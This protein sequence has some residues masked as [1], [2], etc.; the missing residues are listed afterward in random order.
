MTPTTFA[1]AK[2][3]STTAVTC[4][5]SVTYD[6]TAQEPCT[7]EVT[8]AGGLHAS[9]S[10]GYSHNTDAGTATASASF[11]GDANHESSDDSKT[12][13]IDKATSSTAVT[14]PTSVTFDGTAQQP[15]TAEVTGAGG[16]H[17]SLS[18]SYSDNTNA[19]TATASASFDGDA[20]HKASDD[21]TTFTIARATPSV[22]V[23]WSD[24]TFDGT[25]HVATGS[26]SGVGSPAANLGAPDSFTY[27]SGP[28]ATGSPLAGA[29][30][31]AGTYT[32]VAHF[33]GNGNYTTG[34]LG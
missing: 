33:N 23:S 3:P 1:I 29:P 8:G 28:H 7:A 26:V 19:G 20:N 27:Y 13:A 12:F 4:P 30:A 10:V 15:C 21:S 24:W 18:I 17:Q 34:R 16:L 31:D 14:C 22:S 25:A 32:V 9:L 2:A 6:G 11:A 5:D